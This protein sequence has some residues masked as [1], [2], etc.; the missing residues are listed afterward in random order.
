MRLMTMTKS[1][2]AAPLASSVTGF[3][4]GT[5]IRTENGAQA[6][7]TL[8]PGDRVITRY[9]KP[10]NILAVTETLPEQTVIRVDRNAFG[11]TTPR[12]DLVVGSGQLV[13]LTA[14]IL[15]WLFDCTAALLPVRHLTCIAGINE[16]VLDRPQPLLRLQLD[17]PRIVFGSG[18]AMAT[19]SMGQ[20][21]AIRTLA[22]SEVALLKDHIGELVAAA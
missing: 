10:V 21:H 19:E 6:V 13:M 5:A 7:E 8:R 14:P 15:D 11:Q 20:D 18:L 16:I 17:A 22:A 1:E 3:G 9:G 12:R 4:V 2:P